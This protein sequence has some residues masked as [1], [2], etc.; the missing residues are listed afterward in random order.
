[1]TPDDYLIITVTPDD[2]TKMSFS[3][4]EE[5]ISLLTLDDDT[6]SEHMGKLIF[7]DTS[8]ETIAPEPADIPEAREWYAEL[9]R[10]YPY[11]PYFLAT[12][13]DQQVQLYTSMLVP[14]STEGN[15]LSFDK[16]KLEIFAVEKIQAINAFCAAGKL[17]P[18]KS[19]RNFCESLHLDVIEEV[20][21]EPN[22]YP[23]EM[24]KINSPFL[25][26]FFETGY[27]FHTID[28]SDEPVLFALVDDPVSVY[29][30]EST[31]N[32]EL[33]SSS[34]YPVIS[35]EMTT[36][37]QPD[38]PLKM[39][40]VFN[41]DVDRHRKELHA[42]ADMS[43][44][45]CNFMYVKDDQLMHC[46]TRAID[47]PIK[48]RGK[49][50]SLV[51]DASNQLRAIPKDARDFSKAV[52]ELFAGINSN[53]PTF[54]KAPEEVQSD[55]IDIIEEIDQQDTEA[56]EEKTPVEDSSQTELPLGKEPEILDEVD[57]DDI[58]EESG[59][60]RSSVT[61]EKYRTPYD[62][63]IP[64][65]VLPESIQKITR[66]LSKPV[67]KPSKKISEELAIP[68]APK[69]VV[70][71]NEDPLEKTSRR[72]LIMQNNLERCE[73]ENIRLNNDIRVAQEEIERLQREN[74][75][76][77]NRWWKFWK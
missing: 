62:T 51:M 29:Y 44:I 24:E 33:F 7:D 43:Y 14:F 25:Q 28:A 64:T 15:S 48:L 31:L 58:E 19:I 75:E 5:I 4:A 59:E 54:A 21:D 11:L 10:R 68:P 38:N 76:L 57:V 26:E 72:L 6:I 9:D 23:F 46:F 74:M 52:E 39:T 16:H 35:M 3:T 49:I 60:A 17:D 27:Y 69:K 37:D 34:S 61:G 65:S 20:V 30:A 47:L 73:R 32:L 66:A 42:Y 53:K 77:E 55:G 56:P 63:T 12:G 13:E 40:F 1:M 36:Y 67:R 70:A 22:E 2:I 41:I 71:R 18:R 50:R 8:L 45:T